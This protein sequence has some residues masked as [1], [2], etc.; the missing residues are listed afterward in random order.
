[1][2]NYFFVK[3]NA[4][5]SHL[6]GTYPWSGQNI[7]EK[8]KNAKCNRFV[9]KQS[10]CKQVSNEISFNKCVTEKDVLFL[11]ILVTFQSLFNHKNIKIQTAL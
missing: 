8:G 5:Y 4:K 6:L 2:L 9:C 11:C 3:E 10:K 1:M 7:K